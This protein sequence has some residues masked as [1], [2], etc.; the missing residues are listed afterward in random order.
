MDRPELEAR[1]STFADAVIILCKEL[2]ALSGAR[3][4]ADQ[5]SDAAT[6]AAANYRATSRS[7]SRKEF[8]SKMGQVAEEADEAVFWLERVVNGGFATEDRVTSLLKE[9]KELRAIFAASYKTSN[10]RKHR[11]DQ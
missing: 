4:I 8:A 2:R 1:S 10:R 3:N 6:S 7:R 5:L 11:P 9:G